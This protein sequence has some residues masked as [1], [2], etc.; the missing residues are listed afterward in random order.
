MLRLPPSD[1]TVLSLLALAMG[2]AA[3]RV[4]FTSLFWIQSAMLLMFAAGVALLVRCDRRG[5]VPLVRSALTVGVIF[6]CYTT[7]GWL[8][9]ASMPYS[10]D[11]ALSAVDNW[12]FRVDP[13]L[14]LEPY[15]TPSQ[16]E[17]FSF[18]YGAFIPYINVTIALNC[19][20]RPPLEREQFLTGW[21]FLYSLSYLGYLF[22]PAQGPIAFPAADCR[23]A[24]EGGAF[25]DFVQRGVE[26]SGGLQGV[27]PSL[28]VGGSLYLCLFE[29]RVNRLRG[30]IYLPLVL[31]IYA[32]TLVLRYHYVVDLIAGT[33]LA[34]ACLPLGRRAVNAW[35][36]RRLAA[37]LPPLPG[38]EADALPALADAGA[39]GSQTVLSTD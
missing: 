38:G 29:L 25:Y 2:V 21:V 28:H 12:L 27:F 18:A 36:Q 9:A 26:A 1:R 16:I 3:V 8:G 6:T 24:L 13:S 39:G 17:F 5:W 37:G 31:A 7:L 35:V 20:G 4:P 34:L 30:L 11:A 23:V 19:L 14:A 15:L 33:A 10:A 32:A 22:V